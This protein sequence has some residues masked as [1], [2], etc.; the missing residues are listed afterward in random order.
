MVERT[1]A[2]ARL[3][4]CGGADRAATEAFRLALSR[5]LHDSLTQTLYSLTLLSEATARQLHGGDPAAVEAYLAQLGATARQAMKELRLVIHELRSPTLADESLADALERRL[6]AVERRAGVA[7]RLRV[8]AGDDLPVE[9]RTELFQIAQEAL[10]NVLKHAAASRV[11]VE[12]REHDDCLELVIGDD[13]RGFDPDRLLDRGGLGLATMRERAAGL[14]GELAF[15][16]SP[17]GGAQVTVRVPLTRLGR[18]TG[19][20]VAWAR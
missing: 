9:A 6:D 18:A 8:T 19:A 11:V 5:D 12:L 15:A 20:E 16:P 14:G 10:N 3:C 2:L 4:A 1:E 13:G 7:A 17:L